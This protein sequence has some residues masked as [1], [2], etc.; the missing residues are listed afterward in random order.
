MRNLIIFS[1]LVSSIVA[2]NQSNKNVFEEFT[3]IKIPESVKVINDAYQDM[4]Q[5]YGKVLELSL[6]IQSTSELEL[7]VL[8]ST[9]FN[10]SIFIN[11]NIISSELLYSI[12]NR[13]GIWYRNKM[14][15]A[16]FGSTL[17]EK[18]NVTVSIDT[19]HKIAKF[20]YLAD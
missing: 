19:V 16:F 7:S 12:G 3:D 15:Y 17:D 9:F 11:D 6:N 18:E 10:S 2:C 14:G 8:K 1:F 20:Q 13:K 5:D 4:G